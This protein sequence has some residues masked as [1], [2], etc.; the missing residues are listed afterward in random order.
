MIIV[1]R[2]ETDFLFPE[3]TDLNPLRFGDAEYRVDALL[4]NAAY[5]PRGCY[6]PLVSMITAIHGHMFQLHCQK[7]TEAKPLSC[8]VISLPDICDML[9]FKCNRV[10]YRNATC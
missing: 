2:D 9:D 5:D 4:K 1:P 10:R 6:G 3:K 8:S 7:F